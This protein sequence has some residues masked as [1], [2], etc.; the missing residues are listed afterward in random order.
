[1]IRELA[2]SFS[3]VASPDSCRLRPSGSITQ[4]AWRPQYKVS[5]ASDGEG[6]EL[7]VASEDHSL[8]LF[9][10]SVCA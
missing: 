10:V 8:R 9:K 2:R 1:M 5:K 6:M 4:L 7:A 3:S